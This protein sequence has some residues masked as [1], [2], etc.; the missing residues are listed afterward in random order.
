M[1]CHSRRSATPSSMW[2]STS[3]G[4]STRHKLV[5]TPISSQGAERER[6]TT[7]DFYPFPFYCAP[8]HIRTYARMSEKTCRCEA[9]ESCSDCDPSMDDFS[10]SNSDDAS[11]RVDLNVDGL[12]SVVRTCRYCKQQRF[13]AW[14]T[15]RACIFCIDNAEMNLCTWCSNTLTAYHHQCA[16][17]HRKLC[18]PCKGLLCFRCAE[19][20]RYCE[21]CKGY[22]DLRK[23]KNVTK[24]PKCKHKFP[25]PVS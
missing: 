18:N 3:Q 8:C 12:P 6:K 20:H 16:F 5:I 11:Q 7:S 24:C 23:L 14:E 1:T 17:C 19:H 13:V 10:S 2:V 15:A 4:K 21:C 25:L 9:G 22:I